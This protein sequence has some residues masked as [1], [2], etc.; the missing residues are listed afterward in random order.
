M[1]FLLCLR[2]SA[3]RSMHEVI[4][5]KSNYPQMP[6]GLG[7][8]HLV[9][10]HPTKAFSRSSRCCDIGFARNETSGVMDLM[11][12]SEDMTRGIHFHFSHQQVH[13]CWFAKWSRCFYKVGSPVKPSFHLSLLSFF[14]PC[15]LSSHV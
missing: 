3:Q 10:W 6:T 2:T 9:P 4:I 12:S 7:L 14:R 5:G 11:G 13:L 15:S 1:P 8:W